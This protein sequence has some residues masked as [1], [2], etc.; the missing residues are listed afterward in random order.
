MQKSMPAM[1]K[2]VKKLYREMD[3]IIIIE[4][5]SLWWVVVNCFDQY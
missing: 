5:L 1:D 2:F 3:H 4:Y